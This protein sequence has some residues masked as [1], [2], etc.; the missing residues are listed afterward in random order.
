MSNPWKG[1]S[2]YEETDT[3][4]YEF[5]GRTQSANDLYLLISNSLFCTLYGKTGC[6][7]TSLLQA[8]IF[9]LLRQESFLPIVIRLNM[10]MEGDLT[11][12]IIHTIQKECNKQSIEISDNPNWKSDSANS[13]AS[14]FRLW[15]FFYSHTFKNANQEIVFPVIAIDQIEEAFK[16]Q[17]RQTSELLSQL[18]YLVS[19]DLRLPCNCYAN[20]RVVA[21]IREDDL[22]LLED[23]ISDG[24]LNILKQN[25]YRL[26][27]LTDKEAREIIELGI[28][29]FRK[30]ESDLIIDKILQLSKEE[31]GHVSTYMLS[32]LCSQL[33]ITCNGNIT[34]KDVPDSSTGLLQSFYESVI[35]HV[36][37]GT[38]L[39]IENDLIKDDR[40]NIVPLKEFKKKVGATEF[41]ILTEGEYKI[42]QEITAGTTRCVELLH[43]S[44]AKAIKQSKEEQ[45]EKKRQIEQ[46][47]EEREKA[48]SLRKKMKRNTYVFSSILLL[49]VLALTTLLWLISSGAKQCI[50]I[51]EEDETVGIDNYWKAKVSIMNIDEQSDSLCPTQTLDKT[52]FQTTCL[53]PNSD[54]VRVVIQFLAG[55]FNKMD[56]VIA[57]SDSIHIPISRAHGRKKYVGKVIYGSNP[58]QPLKNAVVIVGS[59]IT[60][61]NYKGFF[62]VYVD[63]SDISDDGTVKIY[64]NGYVLQ[65]TRL[66]GDSAEYKL[67]PE[68]PEA[69][70]RRYSLIETQL[71]DKGF[72][73]IG[74]IAESACHLKAYIKNDSIYGY[75]FYDK[76]YEKEKAVNPKNA[77]YAHIIFSGKINNDKTFHL[78]C[79]DWVYNL[80]ELNGT[81]N[82]DGSWEG[83]WNAYLPDLYKFRFTRLEEREQK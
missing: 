28:P 71:A 14:S 12:F 16:E 25:R 24:S 19:D 55:N 80:E 61:S 3:N 27:P 1:L 32:L 70:Q 50:V 52:H 76:S 13:N 2:S 41:K 26:A 59:Q 81:I 79:C 7:K 54:F 11:S 42:V 62:T 66:K 30:E 77:K 47:E 67:Q 31:S 75:Y 44:L 36:S 37:D 65:S 58:A 23:A 10:C 56:T 45:E 74:E 73:M 51:L 39:Y 34:L 15:E 83:Y 29:Y 49:A 18:Y 22:Y 46:L 60:K 72:E 68:D 4:L 43:D 17:Y 63:H 6:G 35:N 20:F 5:K 48:E 78:D 82:N 9:P 38:R 21:I 40:R 69:Y 33:Y 53:K 8:G 57:A 64:K